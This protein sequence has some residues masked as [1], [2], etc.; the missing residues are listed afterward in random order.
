RSGFDWGDSF[1]AKTIAEAFSAIPRLALERSL[2]TE[3]YRV[4][5]W[6]RLGEGETPPAPCIETME[7]GPL[8]EPAFARL[9][10]WGGAEMRR[11]EA[12]ARES[13]ERLPILM[14]HRIA[15]DGP[16]G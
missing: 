11:A 5:L 8:P 9:I 3:L 12:Q 13:S 16:A 15:T 6:R 14:Y 10:V 4:D 7:L 2:R 1:G